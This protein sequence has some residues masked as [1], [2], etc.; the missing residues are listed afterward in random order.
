MSADIP[1]GTANGYQR[2]RC[3]CDGCRAAEVAR[4]REWRKRHRAGKVQH[5]PDA[6]VC[7]PVTVRGKLY[8]SISMA[9]AD[10]GI[11]PATISHQLRTFGTGDRAGLGHAAP[12]RIVL[13][14][15]RPCV[16]HG[17]QF[18]SIEAA[19]RY[20]GVGRTHLYRS[21]RKGVTPKYSEYLLAKLMEADARAGK[22][23]A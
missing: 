9:A 1:H 3:R 8:P 18:V 5:R 21:L 2:Y 19:I 15:V 13:N 14:N 10:L 6:T 23:S 12:K 17:R 22:V 16:I 7:V 4:Q 11:A 20:L